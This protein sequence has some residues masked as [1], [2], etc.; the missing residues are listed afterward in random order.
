[1]APQARSAPPTDSARDGFR[2]LGNFFRW[3]VTWCDHF[4]LAANQQARVIYSRAG[5]GDQSGPA[6]RAPGHAPWR[7]ARRHGD[8]GAGQ[9]PPCWPS[10]R[11]P[12]GI[13]IGNRDRVPDPP[14]I[15]RGH[16]NCDPCRVDGIAVKRGTLGCFNAPGFRS[17]G[18]APSRASL[19]FPPGISCSSEHVR[20]GVND[21]QGRA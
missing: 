21:R 8:R 3:G 6:P 13:G 19:C 17:H 10:A 5:E 4:F 11:G 2:H 7:A 18:P 1:M 15:P 16:S 12:V 14:P 9:G 20:R